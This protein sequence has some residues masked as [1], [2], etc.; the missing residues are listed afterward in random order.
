MDGKNREK[1]SD[2]TRQRLAAA[3]IAAMTERGY[4]GVTIRDICERAG[5]SIGSFY[6]YFD[7]KSDVLREMYETGDELMQ[8]EDEALLARPWMERVSAFIDKYARLNTDTGLDAMRVLYNP[9]NTWFTRV[10][11]MQQKLEALLA[12]AQNAGELTA[13]YSASELTELLFV[14]MRGI[15]YEWCIS[16]GTYDLE[17]RMHHQ[18]ALLLRGFLVGQ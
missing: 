6:R 11:P 8:H 13:E 9:E 3:A 7:T 5:V 18:M 10:R 1:K 12:G 2:R 4:Q 14:C 15:C 17:Q 16:G